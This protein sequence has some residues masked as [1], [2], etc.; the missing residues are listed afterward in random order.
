MFF[1]KQ[2][3]THGCGTVCHACPMIYRLHFLDAGIFFQKL[4][5]LSYCIFLGRFQDLLQ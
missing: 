3:L 1:G 5:L 2:N 4:N